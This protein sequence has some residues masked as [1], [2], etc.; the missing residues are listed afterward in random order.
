MTYF[1]PIRSPTGPPM[2]VPAAT[3]PRNTNRWTCALCTETWNLWI[4]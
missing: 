3:A 2:N 1:R 4:R